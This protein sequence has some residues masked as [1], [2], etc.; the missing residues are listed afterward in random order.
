MILHLPLTFTILIMMCLKEWASL[1]PSCSGLC[2][3][4][5]WVLFSF[6]RFGKFLVIISSDRF[7]ISC[8]LYCP[9]G[10][11]VMQILLYLVLSQRSL[12]L[13]SFLKIFFDFAVPMGCFLL[14]CHPNRCFSLLLHLTCYLFHLMYY[15]FQL[16]C[17]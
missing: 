15:S 2:T 8:F 1:S 9:S 14:P 10:A 5:T 13:R 11:P 12:K 4:W 3:S 17:F 6:T 7:L 16:F